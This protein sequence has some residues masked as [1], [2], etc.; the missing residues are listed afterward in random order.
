MKYVLPDSNWSNQSIQIILFK[1]LKINK[2]GDTMKYKELI[3]EVAEL[4][5][6]YSNMSHSEFVWILSELKRFP[7]N[8]AR[9]VNMSPTTLKN[10][11]ED[12]F[13]ELPLFIVRK[14]ADLCDGETQ[15]KYLRHKYTQRHIKSENKNN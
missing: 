10:F 6:V 11:G 13:N 2:N 7:T 12:E 9:R 14:L 1:F 15:L 5:T 8:F 4:A 3:D